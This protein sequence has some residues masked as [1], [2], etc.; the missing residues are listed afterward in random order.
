MEK[1][2]ERSAVWRERLLA[3]QASG[4]NIG[5]WCKRE[6]VSAWSFYAW[7]KRLALP[8]LAGHADWT[9]IARVYG[10]WMSDA[11]PTAGEK[12]VSQFGGKNPS[13]TLDKVA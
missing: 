2:Q 10:R 9:M 13:P 7:R 1:A 6:G 3:Q 11:D 4:L 5:A 12:A 8:K